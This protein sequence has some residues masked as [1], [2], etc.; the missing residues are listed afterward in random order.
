MDIGLGLSISIRVIIVTGTGGA[1]VLVHAHYGA[2][3][4]LGV[5]GVH[6]A[7]LEAEGV[8][9]DPEGAPLVAGLGPV[10]EGTVTEI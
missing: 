3:R 4:L 5:E 2:W 7:V 8:A 6:E 10:C 1:V 9:Q